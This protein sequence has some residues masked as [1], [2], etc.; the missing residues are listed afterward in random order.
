MSTGSACN[1]LSGARIATP[2]P[3]THKSARATHQLRLAWCRLRATCELGSPHLCM[4][5]LAL[6]F[7]RKLILE[8]VMR[9]CRAAFGLAHK[10][11]LT[12]R[13]TTGGEPA[14]AYLGQLGAC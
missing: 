1:S 4:P 5:R 8:L 11:T 9:P 13:T 10:S 2:I 14:E 7:R 3:R 6:C 12:R